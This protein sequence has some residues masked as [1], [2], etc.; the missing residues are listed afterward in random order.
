M[1]AL[2][3]LRPVQLADRCCSFFAEGFSTKQLKLVYE[4]LSRARSDVAAYAQGPAV[5]WGGYS[6]RRSAR[7]SSATPIL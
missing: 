1:S 4:A 2:V 5:V 6:V 3:P 7:F